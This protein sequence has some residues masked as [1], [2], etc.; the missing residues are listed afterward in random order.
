MRTTISSLLASTTM[1]SNKSGGGIQCQSQPFT[2]CQATDD[3]HAYPL[4]R[5]YT[6]VASFLSPLLPFLSLDRPLNA[7]RML[8]HTPPLLVFLAVR[9]G[10]ARSVRL[11]C[12]Q[13]SPG[14]HSLSLSTDCQQPRQSVSVSSP[15]S[16]LAL[17]CCKM[18]L[19]SFPS[20]SSSTLDFFYIL[21]EKGF[22]IFASVVFICKICF[23]LY[24]LSYCC[25]HIPRAFPPIWM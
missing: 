8:A 19:H 5:P 2:Q 15:W 11:L 4:A 24:C 22:T 25:S 16:D 17:S 9:P 6:P 18:S 1:T 12:F 23:L 3:T 20:L 21:E 14:Y 10:P 13:L 7:R